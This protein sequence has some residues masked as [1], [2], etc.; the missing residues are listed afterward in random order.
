LPSWVAQTAGLVNDVVW[1]HSI[2]TNV[3]CI[4][5]HSVTYGGIKFADDG[6]FREGEVPVLR[7]NGELN[8]GL[9]AI[10][11]V[12]ILNCLGLWPTKAV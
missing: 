1:Q 11:K 3:D 4:S 8:A 7:L 6:D 12:K 10:N 2:R 9:Y 5:V